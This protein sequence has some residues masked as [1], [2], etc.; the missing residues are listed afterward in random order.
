M[1]VL[2]LIITLTAQTAIRYLY[3]DKLLN[4]FQQQVMNSFDYHTN[5]QT[6]LQQYL[7]SLQ[8]KKA[9]TQFRMLQLLG[10]YKNMTKTSYIAQPP[11][12]KGRI[13]AM[14]YGTFKRYRQLDRQIHYK[15][16]NDFIATIKLANAAATARWLYLKKQE[17]HTLEQ[18]LNI[19]SPND[20]VRLLINTTWGQ[21][22]ATR[23]QQH[24]AFTLT[25]KIRNPL[26]GS[27]PITKTLMLPFGIK[28][29]FIEFP[30]VILQYISNSERYVRAV[31]EGYVEFASPLKGL[32][33]VVI[34]D[35]VTSKTLYAGLGKLRVHQGDFVSEGAVLGSVIPKNGKLLL[36]FGIQ[37][38][39]KW[40]NPIPYLF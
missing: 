11:E 6:R 35:H 32:G 5:H 9:M 30:G 12:I 7:K 40:Q 13:A 8:E 33:K 34:L 26:A 4:T 23:I 18:A 2:I 38:G 36:L 29:P 22:L 21:T 1:S 19:K 27:S 39:Q 14:L 17:K 3:L 31:S 25:P 37:K 28:G 20:L 10:T 15:E 16:V 24:L